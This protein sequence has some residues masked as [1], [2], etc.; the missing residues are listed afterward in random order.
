MLKVGTYL[1]DRKVFNDLAPDRR[2]NIGALVDCTL[3][4]RFLGRMK[5]LRFKCM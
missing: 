2:G 4:S 3:V 5:M 1:S